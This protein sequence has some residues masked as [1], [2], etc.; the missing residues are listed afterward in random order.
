MQG[1]VWENVRQKCE[2]LHAHLDLL[3][4]IVVCILYAPRVR[5]DPRVSAFLGLYFA[6]ARKE[7][8]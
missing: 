3:A 1:K 2:S 8:V 7:A 6:H 5:G 4:D